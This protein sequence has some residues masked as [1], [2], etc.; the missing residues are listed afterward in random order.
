[1][2][3]TEASTFEQLWFLMPYSILHFVTVTNSIARKQRERVKRKWK[4]ITVA[5]M[6]IFF[7]IF[8][9]ACAHMY[10]SV[11]QLF[12]TSSDSIFP[13]PN[14]QRYGLDLTRFKDI[15]GYFACADPD[16]ISVDTTDPWWPVRGLID[17]FN[18]NRKVKFH[19]SWIVVIDELMCAF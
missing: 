10:G 17:A 3:V 13:P 12:A 16:S 6:T 15:L 4:D 19:A 14:L 1:M 2:N 11:D 9:G 8:I 18:E 5:E 7:G